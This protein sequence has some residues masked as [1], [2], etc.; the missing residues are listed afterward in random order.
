MR[1]RA[2]H[3]IGIALIALGI[4]AVLVIQVLGIGRGGAAAPNDL[5]RVE[6]VVGSEKQAFFD[7]PQVQRVFAEHGYDVRVV[8]SGSLRMAGLPELNQRDFAFPASA[9]AAK[10]IED[11]VD[12]VLGTHELFF[13]PMAIATFEPILR[14]LEANGVA[15][16][17]AAGQWTIDI[18]AYL[19]LV[20]ADLRWNQLEGSDAYRSPRTV[21]I[22]STD[23]RSSNSAAMYLSLAAYVLA[24]NRVVASEAQA[25]ELLPRLSKLFLAQGYSGSSSAAP[26]ADYLSQGMGAAPMVMIYEGQFLEELSKPNSRITDQMVLAYP[27]PTFFSTHTGVTFSEH[28]EAVMRLIAEDEALARLLAEHGFRSA[29]RHSGM[30]DAVVAEQGLTAQFA[31][32]SSFVNI[33]QEPS[34]EVL[35]YLLTS[36]GREYEIGG[37]PPPPEDGDAGATG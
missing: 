17:D 7:D 6:G 4:A 29:G 15:A 12:G 30:F 22:T 3:V 13:S 31:S 27:S 21:L 18:A 23:I 36:I 14:V 20:E 35:D 24:D 28:G 25:T 1:L 8:S 16:P 32:P 33:A 9:I 26:F 11:K 5:V 19:R 37:S 34:F 10:N 2:P